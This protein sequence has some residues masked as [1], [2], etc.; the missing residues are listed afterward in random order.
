[1]E[2]DPYDKYIGTTVSF[3]YHDIRNKQRIIKLKDIREWEDTYNKVFKK[4]TMNKKVYEYV[5]YYIAPKSELDKTD[6]KRDTIILDSK[7]I[8]ESEDA[9]RT[10]VIRLVPVEWE[11]DFSNITIA[12]RAFR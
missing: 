9:V 4:D 5:A 1:M 6:G 11:N 3:N 8:A 7:I 10:K 12:V 2:Q